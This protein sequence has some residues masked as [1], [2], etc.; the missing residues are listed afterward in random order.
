M[1]F[2]LSK[3]LWLFAAPSRVLLL[4]ALVGVFAGRRFRPL[5]AAALALIAVVAI[6]PVGGF[7]LSKL[8]QTFPP[9]AADAPLD[10]ILVIGGALDAADFDARP[11]SGFNSAFGRLYEAARLAKSHPGAK[12]IDIGGPVPSE[13]GGRAEA[14]AAADV[15]VALGVPRER[16]VVERASRNTFEN[17]VNAAALVAP[18]SN[19]AYALVTSAFHM[20]RAVGCF[21]K[22]GFDVRPDPV[23]YRWQ[24]LGWGFDVAGGLD[25]LDLATHEYFGLLSYRLMGRTAALWPSPRPPGA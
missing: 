20:P 12:V 3:A 2:A 19:R 14:D 10:G 13:P 24:S 11:G 6:A 4:A 18:G 22:A 15:L 17:A 9:L 5:A 21:R 25:A 1:L 23:D 8:E 7:A 16:I